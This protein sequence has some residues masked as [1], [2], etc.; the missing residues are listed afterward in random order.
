MHAVDQTL[1]QH[2]EAIEA[3]KELFWRQGYED[4]SVEALVQA[5]GYNR[6]AIYNS[7]GGKLELFLAALEEYYHER[8]N[9]FFS[10]LSDPQ[11]GP[12]DA[13]REVSTFC[14]KEMTERGAGCLMC[15]VALEVGQYEP[16][17]AER[18]ST[19]LSEIEEAK[20]AALEIAQSR[21]ELNP[22]ITPKEGAALLIS[23][24]LGC[25]VMVRNGASR[26]HILKTFQ[27]L[28]GGNQQYANPGR[29]AQHTHKAEPIACLFSLNLSRGVSHAAK[30]EQA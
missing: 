7:F 27:R 11:R 16:V 15:N 28:Y 8:K 19:Y 17:I 30:Y 12:L 24:M 22:A 25:G 13:I 9:L 18:V 26:Q 6:Y 14:I 1:S 21:G 2:A 3:A 4:T 20:G 29:L 5:T 10:A 23:N